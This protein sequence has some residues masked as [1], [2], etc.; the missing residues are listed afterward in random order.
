MVRWNKAYIKGTKDI[1]KV[2]DDLPLKT[3]YV[4][5][6]CGA[7]MFRR[8]GNKRV[9]H[10][11]HKETTAK[12]NPENYFHKLGKQIFKEI[13]DNSLEFIIV[14]S[15]KRINLKEEYGECFIEDNTA[16]VK[17]EK[18]ADLYIK[19]LQDKEKDIVVEI[20]FTHQVEKRKIDKAFRII[21]IRL[22]DKCLDNDATSDEVE[23]EIR[24]ICS[25]PL[26]NNENVRLYNFEENIVYVE[27]QSCND[28][29]SG[30]SS[31]YSFND[32]C[33]GVDAKSKSIPKFRNYTSYKTGSNDLGGQARTSSGHMN[34]PNEKKTP[35]PS[36]ERKKEVPVSGY[37]LQ[38]RMEVIR[39]TINFDVDIFIKSKYPNIR[40]QPAV[41]PTHKNILDIIVQDNDKEYWIGIDYKKNEVFQGDLERKIPNEWKD[42]VREYIKNLK[43]VK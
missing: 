23:E 38:P 7:D 39:P 40:H 24:K 15:S 14:P 6:A 12:C 13:Y 19:H 10:F 32:D 43:Q 22:P 37:L 29:F 8:R 18:N 33:L 1:V 31:A 41:L 25:S 42:A 20:L 28:L 16:N 35:L 30:N 21:E 34:I 27:A 9:H 2:D 26:Y 17:L 4:C 36:S 11:A 3:E 5:I